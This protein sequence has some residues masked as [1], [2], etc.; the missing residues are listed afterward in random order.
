MKLVASVS[1]KTKGGA[2]RR[3]DDGR[4]HPPAEY[5][6]SEDIGR[7][8]ERYRTALSDAARAE[9]WGQRTEDSKKVPTFAGG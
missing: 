4:E 8:F 2:M 9:R 5:P 1:S 7:L 3:T 6:T